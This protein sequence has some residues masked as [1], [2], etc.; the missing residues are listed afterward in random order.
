VTEIGNNHNKSGPSVAL[1]WVIQTDGILSTQSDNPEHLR[2]N[3]DIF[4][5]TLDDDEMN[6]LSNATRPYGVPSYMCSDRKE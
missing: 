5:W 1:R 4:D 3:L 6:Q 2:E